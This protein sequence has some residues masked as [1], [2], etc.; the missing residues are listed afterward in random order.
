M[1]RWVSERTVPSPRGLGFIGFADPGLN[2]PNKRKS[3]TCRGPRSRPGLRLC[4]PAGYERRSLSNRNRA[5]HLL[6]NFLVLLGLRA[7]GW[8]SDF[9]QLLNGLDIMHAQALKLL[10][11]QVFLDVLAIIRRQNNVCQ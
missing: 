6:A 2:H 3:G 7:T 9:E 10:R 8:Q 5:Q 1:G 11:R 4:R